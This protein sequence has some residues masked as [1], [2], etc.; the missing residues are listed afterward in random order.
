MHEIEGNIG[1]VSMKGGGTNS[2]IAPRNCMNQNE[3]PRGFKFPDRDLS[4]AP[5]G[6]WTEVLGATTVKQ[7]THAFLD[8]LDVIDC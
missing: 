4:E 5:L 2:E 3:K 7:S 1:N 8:L 6:H